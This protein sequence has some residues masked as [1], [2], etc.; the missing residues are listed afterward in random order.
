MRNRYPLGPRDG[1]FGL[2]LAHRLRR[3][4]LAFAVEISRRYGDVASFRLGPYRSYVIN[5]PAAMRARL[6]SRGS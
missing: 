1:L 5:H 4:P 2:R 6:A 3:E